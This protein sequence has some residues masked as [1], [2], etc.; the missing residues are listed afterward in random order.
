MQRSIDRLISATLDKDVPEGQQPKI[1]DENG[2]IKF[3]RI[4]YDLDMYN[5]ILERVNGFD[6]KTLRGKMK[7]PEQDIKGPI[8]YGDN[9]SQS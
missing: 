3:D 9:L 7:V 4:A 6:Y 8:N 2:K 1:I 5:S